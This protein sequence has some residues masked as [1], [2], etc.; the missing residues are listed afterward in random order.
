MST[1]LRSIVLSGLFVLGCDASVSSDGSGGG[2]EGGQGGGT[3]SACDAP[4][5]PKAFEIGTGEVCFERLA[6]GQ[7]VPLVQGPQG[8]FHVWVAM[9]CAGCGTE[10][11]LRYGAL[12]PATGEHFE[13][14]YPNEGLFELSGDATS[15]Q[16]AMLTAVMPGVP[17][18]P[19][20]FPPLEKGAA[21]R[22]YVEHLEDGMVV[23]RSEVDVIL[24]DTVSWDPC[25]ENPESEFCG[26]G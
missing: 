3:P 13:N 10:M 15:R 23:E 7:E 8:G 21:V 22:L 1:L 19:V 2:G 6:A 14:T 20:A 11:H 16:R 25:A 24:G 5:S 12:D 18:D 17:W 9:S 4:P 26:F